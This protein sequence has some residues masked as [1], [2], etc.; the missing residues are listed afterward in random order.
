MGT[1]IIIRIITITNLIYR[2][3]FRHQKTL[4]KVK[5]WKQVERQIQNTKQ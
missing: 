5:S 1:V 3:L 2:V 4:Y